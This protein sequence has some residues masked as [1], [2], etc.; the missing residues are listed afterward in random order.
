MHYSTVRKRFYP[1]GVDH[2][3]FRHGMKGSPTWRSWQSMLD[4]CTN[5]KSLNYHKYGGRGIKV[6]AEWLFFEHFYADMGVRPEGKTL[7]RIDT[8]GNYEPGNCRWATLSEQNKNRR[9]VSAEARLKMSASART[10]RRKE[11][12]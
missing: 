12:L 11:P 5:S 6:C 10:R 1:T 7:D 2:P 4:R 8:Y 3:M 9:P